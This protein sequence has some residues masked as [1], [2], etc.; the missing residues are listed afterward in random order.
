VTVGYDT[1]AVHQSRTITIT[2]T[3]PTQA[4]V[5]ATNCGGLALQDLIGTALSDVASNPCAD[6]T[7]E[8]IPTTLT[9]TGA[10]T[11]GYNEPATV[12]ANLVDDLSNA[13]DSQSVTFTLNGSETCTANTDPSGNASCPITPGEVAGTYSLIASFAGTS[14]YGPSTATT[15]FVITLVLTAP[16]LPNPTWETPYS[17]TITALGGSGIVTFSKASGTLPT[18]LSLEGN[19]TLI[20]TPTDKTQIGLTFTFTVE[21]TDPVPASGT[22]SYTI[23]LLSPCAGGLTPYFLSATS[24]TGNFTGFF[25]VNSSGVALYTQNG[26]GHGTGT[27]TT[28]GGVTRITAFGMNM[29]LLG[30]RSGAFS[31]FVETAP[32]PQKAGTFTLL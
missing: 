23:K 16:P 29:A 13:L 18:G 8:L 27:L 20:G 15:S 5:L 11:Q 28:S 21:A 3:V 14:V 19:G 22:Q 1:L 32:G 6:T 2:V 24:H 17:T 12:S 30:E 4:G 9:Y 31:T 26:G 25:C 7:P 10:T